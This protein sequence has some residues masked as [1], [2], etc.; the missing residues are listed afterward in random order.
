[1]YLSLQIKKPDFVSLKMCL[2]QQI[3]QMTWQAATFWCRS[4][5]LAF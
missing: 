4:V 2:T 1:M 3:G 5:M